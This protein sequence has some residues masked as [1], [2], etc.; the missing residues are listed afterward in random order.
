M[1][2]SYVY[3]VHMCA[4]HDVL[5]AYFHSVVGALTHGRMVGASRTL[6][7]GERHNGT[8]LKGPKWLERGE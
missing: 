1:N 2:M 3:M 4:R 6:Q 7:L 8:S 5:D